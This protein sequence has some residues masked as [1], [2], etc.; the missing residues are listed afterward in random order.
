MKF[1]GISILKRPNCKTWYARYRK[2]GKQIYISAKT[3]QDCYNKLKIALKQKAKSEAK[4]L[5]QA[6]ELKQNKAKQIKFIEWFNKWLELYKMNVKESTKRDYK[7]TFNYLTRLYNIEINKITALD[8][9]EILNKVTFERRKQKVYELLK[10]I[11]KK[12]KINK[13]VEDNPLETI[14]KPKHKKVNGLAFSNEDEKKLIE[15]LNN[16]KLDIFLVS[17]YQ[18]LRRGE[19]LAL[20]INDFDFEKKTLTINKSLNFKN[21]ID[22]TKNIYS[23]RVMPLFE[24]TIRIVEK[25]KNKQGRIFNYSQKQSAEIFKKIIEANFQQKKYTPHSLRHT[26]ITKCQE[27]NIPLHII[28]KWVGHNIGSKVTNQVYTHTR[29]L[30][31][32]ENIEKMNNY[33]NFR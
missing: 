31:E 22:E 6:E 3:Q 4:E 14:E 7:A 26:F 9:I 32:L 16:K 11:F 33:T 24:N 28:Q 12:A 17:L 27:A 25:Y 15:I 29:E 1:R 10:D 21:E 30:A 2:N 19:A 18:G 23:N 13:L 20:N 8:I 5:I